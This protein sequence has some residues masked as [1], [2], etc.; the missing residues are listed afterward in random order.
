MLHLAIPLDSSDELLMGDDERRAFLAY[1]PRPVGPFVISDQ[2]RGVSGY[3]GVARNGK[4]FKAQIR[5][6]STLHYLGTFSTAIDAARAYDAKARELHGD[7]AILNF[8]DDGEGVA[9]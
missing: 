2:P 5:W 1:D 6:H 7:L 4:G 8:S 3:R 9:A